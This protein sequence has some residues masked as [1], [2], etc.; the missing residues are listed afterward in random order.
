MEVRIPAGMKSSL[1]TGKK[2]VAHIWHAFHTPAMRISRPQEWEPPEGNVTTMW[3]TGST[4]S[5]GSWVGWLEFVDDNQ[6]QMVEGFHG[7]IL[8]CASYYTAATKDCCNKAG[9][10]YSI[11]ITVE[12]KDPKEQ[13]MQRR[14]RSGRMYVRLFLNALEEHVH[15]PRVCF[16]FQH[17]VSE[18]ESR[19]GAT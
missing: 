19:A 15:I 11:T 18:R 1:V 16:A 8:Y 3:N 6:R 2:F 4:R 12:Q 13:D 5:W 9:R 7:N 14:C 10:H 17:W